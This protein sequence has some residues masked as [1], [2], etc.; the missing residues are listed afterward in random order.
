MIR[1]EAN[2]RRA[3]SLWLLLLLAGL[4]LPRRAVAQVDMGSISGTVRDTS[5][6]VLTGVNVGDWPFY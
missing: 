6:A 5:G 3:F 2:T 4:V 1:L